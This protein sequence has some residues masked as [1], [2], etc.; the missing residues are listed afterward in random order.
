MDTNELSEFEKVT[1]SILIIRNKKVMIDADLA[2]V[3][4]VPT[5]QLNQAVKR[6]IQRFPE[7]FMFQLNKEERDK[8][9]AEC[10]HLQ[11]LKFSPYMPYAFTEHGALMLASILNSDAAI[12]AC[13]HVVRAFIKMREILD[14]QVSLMESHLMRKIEELEQRNQQHFDTLQAL[15]QELRDANPT[16]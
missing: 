2:R 8:V 1:N 16:A 5:K 11:N 14:N 15:L 12:R 10:D 9:V 7:D 4:Q 3:Y 6:N 13:V